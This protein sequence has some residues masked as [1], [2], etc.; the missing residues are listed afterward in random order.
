MLSTLISDPFAESYLYC[1]MTV[2][3]GYLYYLE[4]AAK[5]EQ[6]TDWIQALLQNMAGNLITLNNY[7]N[8]IVVANENKDSELYSFILG[9]IF[10]A[11]ADF[12]P[13]DLEEL[14]DFDAA[15]NPF[16]EEG[17]QKVESIVRLFSALVRQTEAIQSEHVD[18]NLYQHVDSY[19]NLEQEMTENMQVRNSLPL[20]TK[21][22]RVPPE[23]AKAHPFVR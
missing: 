6:W 14:D 20:L 17:D 11:L 12:E 21:D 23:L 16:M 15:G 18:L 4:E 5:Y 10:Y 9:K 19:A 8:K 3:D 13:I 7:Y 2:Y 1:H 22:V